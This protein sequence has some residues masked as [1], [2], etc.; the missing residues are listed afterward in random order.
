LYISKGQGNL[1]LNA[2][3]GTYSVWKNIYDNFVVFPTGVDKSR[4]LGAEV[5]L[6]GEVSNQDTL[7]NN[8]WMRS[9]AFAARVWSEKTMI[10]HELVAKLV[11]NQRAL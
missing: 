1:W 4:I 11:E 3:Q 8:L 2:T 6:W 5:C 9:S 7:E 10:L